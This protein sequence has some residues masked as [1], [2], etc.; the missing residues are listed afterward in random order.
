MAFIDE[1][2]FIVYDDGGRSKYFKAKDVRD[3]V[4]R[5]LAIATK[6]DYKEVYDMLYEEAK[7]SP[8]NGVKKKAWKNVARKLGG[9]WHPC[10][11]IGTGCTMHLNPDEIPNE[12]R[13][14]MQVSKHL[15]AVI[16]GKVHDTFDCTRD[17]ERCVYGYW[18][19]N[20]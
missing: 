14:V 4:T 5:A 18:V 17:G 6:R 16:N 15:C 1:N 10:T 11:G 3:C 19:F 13:M 7:E 20:N 12:K 8:R 9:V 2:H